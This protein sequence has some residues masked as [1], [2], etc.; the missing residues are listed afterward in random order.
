MKIYLQNS[1]GTCIVFHMEPEYDE[2]N[3]EYE[4]PFYVLIDALETKED[5][6]YQLSL[7]SVGS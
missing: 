5:E 1:D 4:D 6:D 3:P 7:D 2:F